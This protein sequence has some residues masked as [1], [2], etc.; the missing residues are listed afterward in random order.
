MPTTHK[1]NFGIIGNCAYSALID[2]QA[3]V[4]WMCL[5][6]FDSSFIFGGLL[7]GDKGGRFSIQPEWD[8]YSTR[9]QYIP[10]TN[11]L[12]TIFDCE[13]GQYKVID[14]APRF[15]QYERY[16]KPLMLIRKIVPIKG[17]PRIRV[18][19]R[20]VGNY[21]ELQPTKVFGSS[22]IRFEGL[23]S[24][25]R[26]TTNIP[27]TYIDE[28]LPFVLNETKYLVLSWGAPLEAAL[29]SSVESFLDQTTSYWQHWVKNTTT[30]VFEQERVIRSALTIKLHQF[31]DT[32][33]MIAA[34]TTSL[35]E[36][37]GK[38]RNRDYR[39]CWLRDAHS[40][41]KALNDLSHFSVLEDFVNFIENIALNEHQRFHPLYPI[42]LTKMPNERILPLKGY[43]GE[44]P[45]RIGNNTYHAIQNDIYGE[46]LITLLPFFTDK[47]LNVNDY[48]TLKN[49]V[50]NCL[51]LIDETMHEPDTAVW[52]NSL[53]EGLH[54]YTALYHWAGSKAARKIA[55]YLDDTRM[56]KLA[57]RLVKEAA[58]R[59][60]KC[61]DETRGVYTIA[62]GSTELDPSLLLLI[63]AGY[64]DSK[65][66]R[67]ARHMA[68]LEAQ[69]KSENG[70]MYRHK[71]DDADRNEV[72]HLCASYWYVEAL[73]RMERID[74]AIVLF[75]QL[76][77]YSNNLGLLSEY[78]DEKTASQWGNFPHTYAHVS[79][80]N[81]AFMISKRL[82]KP[83]YL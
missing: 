3:N 67:A 25:V 27:L 7:D 23:E 11:I 40:T 71:E 37:P 14:F 52:D 48:S 4:S 75:K 53:I 8:T 39:Y 5:P 64:L 63:N 6:R 26:L 80:I 44:R 29:E 42:G 43:R 81:A 13:D 70:L 54:T 2:Q 61:F 10:N 31:Q 56:E 45:V 50:M 83:A 18:S 65:S 66:E 21:G 69:L 76:S 34:T 58:E 17:R 20:P 36:Y 82:D 1:Y 24:K 16:Y 38:T 47:R 72:A 74:E 59:I 9:Q 28:E 79:E 33:A 22:H 15:L 78:V 32:G 51:T 55:Q 49:V 68:V 57:D 60:E 41:I 19:C 62:E 30:G 77:V 73:A 12:E 35:P 46:V